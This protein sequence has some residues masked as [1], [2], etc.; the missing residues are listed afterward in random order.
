[1]YP[2]PPSPSLESPSTLTVSGVQGVIDVRDIDTTKLFTIEQMRS[3]FVMVLPELNIKDAQ[4]QLRS[5]FTL[6]LGIMEKYFSSPKH[7][8]IDKYK[9]KIDGKEY[10]FYDLKKYA[11]LDLNDKVLTRAIAESAFNIYDHFSRE[12]KVALPTS[13]TNFKK[14]VLS[15]IYSI[16]PNKNKAFYND[17][18]IG[19]QQYLKLDKEL[20]PTKTNFINYA[21][22]RAQE[23]DLN[24]NI[25]IIGKG[26]AGKSTK[27]LQDARHIYAYKW[28]LSLAETEQRLIKNEWVFKNIIYTNDQS[29]APF[30]EGKGEIIAGD[31][32][33]F[34][35]DA[36][37]G[38]RSEN[39]KFTSRA[40]IY[41]DR[42]NICYSLIQN[43]PDIDKRIKSGA[44]IVYLVY[45]RSKA[46]TFIRHGNLPIIANTHDFDIFE[47]KPYLLNDP[48]K[49]LTQLRKLPSYVC[50]VHFRDMRGNSKTG[51]RANPLWEAYAGHKKEFQDENEE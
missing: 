31:E 45:E 48:Q 18:V 39:I 7:N 2:N 12:L 22:A 16:I 43:Y 5:L 19:F 36:R 13:K 1:M 46:L 14:K 21:V 28:K 42:N 35:A 50:D 11:D 10:S 4:E 38:M 8:D 3:N 20:R 17:F 9:I 34:T 44:N 26:R 37:A 24:I 23:F 32:S 29:L 30:K 40:N 51:F 15:R 25:L 33:Y 41:A 27:M 6:M 49:G 47:K